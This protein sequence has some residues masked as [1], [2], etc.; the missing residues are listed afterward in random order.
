[1]TPSWFDLLSEDGRRQAITI[2]Q[3][4][5]TYHSKPILEI[6]EK[7]PRERAEDAREF[8]YDKFFDSFLISIPQ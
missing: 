4:Y 5:V 8:W 2:A 7:S 3:D 1:M 6:L